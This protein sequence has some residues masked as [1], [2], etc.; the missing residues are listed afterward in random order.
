MTRVRST[1]L[2]CLLALLGGVHCT[3]PTLGESTRATRND[4][5][6]KADSASW[7]AGLLASLGTPGYRIFIRI[8]LETDPVTGI[9]GYIAGIKYEPVTM[10]FFDLAQSAAASQADKDAYDRFFNL[11][12]K[13]SQILFS[14]P[15]DGTPFL[16]YLCKWDAPDCEFSDANRIAYLRK[17]TGIMNPWGAAPPVNGA[18]EE[19]QQ[20]FV[21]ILQQQLP[22]EGQA[23]ETTIPGSMPPQTTTVRVTNLSIVGPHLALAYT[24]DDD[25]NCRQ[26][27]AIYTFVDFTSNFTI[28]PSR[29]TKVLAFGGNPPDMLAD[30]YSLNAVRN[31]WQVKPGSTTF[32]THTGYTRGNSVTDTANA[33]GALRDCF[34]VEPA[35]FL[36]ANG[37]QEDKCIASDGTPFDCFL[38]PRFK[39]L[40]RNAI[41]G[42]E[43]LPKASWNQLACEYAALNPSTVGTTNPCKPPPILT[44]DL[45]LEQ[46]MTVRWNPGPDD[47]LFPVVDAEMSVR[48]CTQD[49]KTSVDP[50]GSCE[51]TTTL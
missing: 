49:P 34:V 14:T 39:C 1:R 2:A 19:L 22:T 43:I 45:T 46:G 31:G 33:S 8:T 35:V 11:G 16:V 12:A 40:I 48:H 17:R 47:T 27:E 6:W 24:G 38:G 36:A 4:N 18:W 13:L 26:L 15:R 3:A 50:I 37:S 9:T 20:P 23:H 51:V 10:A 32:E 29:F 28:P 25:A 21:A 44:L 41:P 7:V 30:G 42:A 5:C